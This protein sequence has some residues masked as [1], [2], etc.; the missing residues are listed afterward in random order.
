MLPSVRHPKNKHAC[1]DWQLG[2]RTANLFAYFNSAPFIGQLER[3][4]ALDGIFGDP[5]IEG[6]GIHVTSRGGFLKM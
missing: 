3:I 2:D 1:I 4:T 6:G 5:W